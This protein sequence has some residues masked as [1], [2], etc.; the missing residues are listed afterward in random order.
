[1]AA[2][3]PL[4]RKDAYA[5]A[6]VEPLLAGARAGRRAFLDG[7][8]LAFARDAPLQLESGGEPAVFL[9]AR[10][11][12]FRS[13]AF[14]DGRRSILDVLLPG[15]IVGL[16]SLVMARPSHD[17][18]AAGN[19]SGKLIAASRLRAM[20][21]EQ[22][23]ATWLFALMSEARERM[24][25]VAASVARS[26]ARERLA[27]FF[28]D[29]YDR[30]RRRDLAI[31][32]SFDLPLTQE[33]IGDHLGLT[34]VHVNRVLRQ[35][36]EAGLMTSNRNRVVLTDVERLRSLALERRITPIAEVAPRSRIGEADGAAQPQG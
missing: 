32:D 5:P 6:V 2:S 29:I 18:H 26:D 1:L 25:R 14:S 9:V 22:S 11:F 30:L 33:Q 3:T 24:D 21:G 15:D 13:T 28:L 36:R 4:E 12:A 17:F 8:S 23:T 35:L 34:M 20:L 10:G 31:G 19:V 27:A 16:E 7:R